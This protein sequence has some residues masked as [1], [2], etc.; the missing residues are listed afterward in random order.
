VG[1]SFFLE[2]HEGLELVAHSGN[3][4]GF[5]SHFYLHLPTRTAFIVGY[6]TDVSTRKGG[7]TFEVTRKVDADL[8]D[9]ILRRVF[10]D[11]R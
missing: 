2:R 1:L 9:E 3:Q 8:R 4:N 11:G 7:K 10:R 6:N 5:L